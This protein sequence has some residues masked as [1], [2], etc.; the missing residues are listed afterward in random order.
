MIRWFWIAVVVAG[1]LAAALTVPVGGR[2]LWQRVQGPASETTQE[3]T[4]V[5]RASVDSPAKAEPGLAA[6]AGQGRAD[7][8]SAPGVGAEQSPDHHTDADRKALDELIE[9]KLKAEP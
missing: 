2:T 5:A 9:Q 3:S 7:A 6:E 4:S 8:A 1:L